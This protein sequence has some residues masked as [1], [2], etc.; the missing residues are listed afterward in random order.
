MNT[1]EKLKQI[2]LEVA[3]F[4]AQIQTRL[5][6]LK[7]G[8]EWPRVNDLYFTVRDDGSI[9]S[10]QCGV[11]IEYDRSCKK[12]GNVYRTREAAQAADNQIQF[13][14]RAMTAGDLPPDAG[15]GFE[16]YYG[17]SGNLLYREVTGIDGV[18]KF[19][20]IEKRDSFIESEGGIDIVREKL[21]KGWPV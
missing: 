15:K 1:D 14:R 9:A 18:R 3:Y 20:T 17:R 12:R 11:D 4:H 13:I 6:A 19:S 21:R 16:V 2:E 5:D 10:R 8:D 7:G